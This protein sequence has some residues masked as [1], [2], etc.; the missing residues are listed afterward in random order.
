MVLDL[1]E[2]VASGGLN[3]GDSDAE[4]TVAFLPFEA[5]SGWE[6]LMDPP[7][8][9][10]L[11]EL[12]GLRDGERRWDRQQYVNMILNT[13]DSE[14]LHSILPRDSAEVGPETRLHF[15]IKERSS[16]GRGP[17]AVNQATDIGMHGTLPY[18][19]TRMPMKLKLHP[20]QDD[21]KC[22]PQG[23]SKIAHR[24]SGGQ[25]S[26]NE[27]TSSEGAEEAWSSGGDGRLCRPCRDLLFP[28]GSI[29]Q[30]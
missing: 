13:A 22:F 24:F 17:D 14:G 2:N 23:V 7:G 26:N 3:T 5:L 15:S 21:W 28:G 12:D 8:R 11:Q 29:P 4:C 6:S 25:M 27:A 10:S 1:S 20:C 30:R 9:V 16:L 18:E 19:T